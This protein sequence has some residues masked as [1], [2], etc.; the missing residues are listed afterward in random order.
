MALEMS[1]F[2][3]RSQTRD[4]AS[5]FSVTL[6]PAALSLAALGMVLILGWCFYMGFMIGRGQNPEERLQRIAAVLQP[7]GGASQ[8]AQGQ[9]DGAGG[10]PAPQGVPEP[11]AGQGAVPAPPAQG[12]VPGYPVF[13]TQGAGQQAQTQAQ[14]TAQP[15]A[16]QPQQAKAQPA[17]KADRAQAGPPTYT[18]VYRMATVFTRE[19]ARREQER[20]E[21]KGFSTSIRQSGKSWGLLHTFKG[22]DK[23]C[24]AFLKD[25][26]RAGLGQPARVSRKKN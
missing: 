20:Y 21:N 23:D 18:F 22:T 4:G 14:A 7:G 15:G 9:A 16:S 1:Q 10:E 13:Q 3:H 8:P 2:V 19:D 5:R 11:A 26:K 25:V 12:Q 17:A 24:E 6:S